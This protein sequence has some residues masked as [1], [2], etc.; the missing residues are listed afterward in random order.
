MKALKTMTVLLLTLSSYF[1]TAQT[2]PT[3]YSAGSI[4]LSDG[5]VKNG[6]IKEN[7]RKKAAISFMET[8]DSKAKAYDGWSLNAIQIGDA[9][10]Q[11]LRGDFF[12][13]LCAGELS[14][15]QKTTEAEAKIDYNGSEPILRSTTEGKRNDYYVL[16]ATTKELVLVTEKNYD[17][18]VATLFAAYQPAVAKAKETAPSPAQLK[19][20]VELFNQRSGK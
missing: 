18:T 1:V 2:A 15:L 12:T 14:F 6:Y 4:T 20:A 17:Q 19:P 7:F 9:R 13:V 5:T 10:Y 8:P 3:G 11:C 16:N